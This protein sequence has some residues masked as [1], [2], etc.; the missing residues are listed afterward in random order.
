MTNISYDDIAKSVVLFIKNAISRQ[1]KAINPSS[2]VARM[3]FPDPIGNKAPTPTPFCV[4]RM[5]ESQEK[6]YFDGTSNPPRYA[7]I[8]FGCVILGDTFTVV[9]AIKDLITN[10]LT[11]NPRIV[12]YRFLGSDS[13]VGDPAGTVLIS[14]SPQSDM[15][16]DVGFPVREV[17][18]VSFSA[19]VKI[20]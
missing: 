15:P 17:D 1:V 4:I 18:S 16:G 14:M 19:R 9:C 6:T 11:T 10:A 5:V 2:I 20:R 12:L 8:G 13:P 3:N 7:K